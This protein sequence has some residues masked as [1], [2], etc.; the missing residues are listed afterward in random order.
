MKKF[1]STTGVAALLVSCAAAQDWPRYETSLQYTFTR[2]NSATNLSAFNANG[3]SG[4]FAYN[5]NRWFGGV[6]DLGAVHNGRVLDST[7][8]NYLAGPRITLYRASRI[9]PYFQVLFGG[10]YATSSIATPFTASVQ[11]AGVIPPGTTVRATRQETGF[12]MTAGGG[13][14]IKMGKHVSFRPIQ[15][16]YFL[17][18]L[19]N[20]RTASDN[21]QNNVRYSAGLNFMFGGE[22]PTPAPPPTQPL[23]TCPD[24]SK[25]PPDGTCPKLNLKASLS[26]S[27]QEL[28]QGETAQVNASIAGADSNRLDFQWSVNGQAVSK[29]HSFTFETSGR[30]PGTYTV[31]L[32]VSGVIFNPASA[33]TNVTVREYIPP[34]ATLQASPAEIFAGEKSTLTA[35]CQGQCGGTL[36][37]PTFTA[38]EGL[39]QGN[40]FDSSGVQFDSSDNGE[41]RKTITITS[42][43]V[44]S[45]SS[46]AATTTITVIKKAVITPIRLPD[47][48]FD[49]NS[50]RV[51]N[52]G[53]RILLEQLRAYFERDSGG[54]VVLVGHQSSD[55]R[56]AN[57]AEQ[58]ALNAAAVITAGTGV[59]LSIPQTQ[60]LVSFPGVEQNGVPFQSGF[61]SSSVRGSNSTAGEMRRVEVWFVPADGQLPGSL[62]D[63][64][65][66]S[67]LSVSSLGCPR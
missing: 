54:K 57:L 3:G 67:A 52:C 10:V 17:T 13:L 14:D 35:S 4:Q 46:G 16:E 37:P 28:C 41:Q 2:F 62:K 48:L 15:V 19:Q 39:V 61:C 36:Q 59:C 42:T 25:V 51:N 33:Q 65:D 44:D 60:V 11:D 34:S 32:T 66:A 64:Q 12:A 47:V 6:M 24:G 31:S 40:Q 22:E 49:A 27:R 8:A 23:K 43:C 20:L 29:E 1:I 55:E 45:R 58:R 9:R 26:A 21:N 56:S 63:Y 7:V 53:K 30:D 38:S 5:F 50:A 18:R